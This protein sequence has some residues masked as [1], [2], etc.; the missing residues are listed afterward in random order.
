MPARARAAE[1]AYFFFFFG[2]AGAAPPPH[3]GQMGASSRLSTSFVH[4]VAAVRLEERVRGGGVL[5]RPLAGL[6]HLRLHD[7]ER[8][9]CTDLA[10]SLRELEGLVVASELGVEL[11]D[12]LTTA[13]RGD[14]FARS[15]RLFAEARLELE[16]ALEV[17]RDAIALPK[18]AREALA[19]GVVSARTG[20]VEEVDRLLRILRHA[21]P[22]GIRRRRPEA[23]RRVARRAAPRERTEARGRVGLLGLE[24]LRERQ[25]GPCR[26]PALHATRA[27][28]ERRGLRVPFHRRSACVYLP[29]GAH[30]DAGSSL[31]RT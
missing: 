7:A 3:F 24:H 17:L 22:L 21:L 27:T 2:V 6:L 29:L 28:K 14:P 10:R 13:A 19:D 4:L 5:L 16:R 31:G 15:D 26:R 25:D 8:G 18:L 9:I 23:S 20:P 1:L 11:G 30:T 12:F